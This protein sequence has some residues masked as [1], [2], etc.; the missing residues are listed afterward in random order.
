MTEPKWHREINTFLE[1]KP[2]IILD[3][4]VLDQFQF[5]GDSYH[6]VYLPNY[7]YQLLKEKGYKTVVLYDEAN[8]FHP[9]PGKED[10]MSRFLELC[11]DYPGVHV[12]NN[13][14]PCPFIGQV[15][16][17]PVTTTRASLDDSN[18]ASIGQIIEYVLGQSDMSVAVIMDM[19]SRYIVS[20]DRM[21]LTDV[22]AYTEIL[23]AIRSAEEADTG[24]NLSKNALIL[25]T[26][27]VNDLPTWFYLSNPDV[28]IISIPTPDN[29]LRM[30]FV[31]GKQFQQF[32]Q[33]EIYSS[34]ILFYDEH[35]ELLLK[36]RK[37]FVGVTE[38]FTYTD[39]LGIRTICYR[40][41][42]HISQLSNV[43]DFYR[44]GIKENKWESV[45]EKTIDALKNDLFSNILGQDFALK[46]VLD[47]V[48]RSVIS[49]NGNVASN[50]PKGILFFAGPT[51]TGKTETAKA[52]ARDIFGDE[53]C[54]LRFDMAEY[55]QSHSDQKLLGAPPGYVGYEAGGQL[56]NAVRNNPFS[57]ILFDEIE[58]A[59]PSILDKFLQI[60][61][62]GR[63]TDGQGNTVYF[64][65][66]IIVFTSNEGIIGEVAEIDEFGEKHIT[67]KQLIEASES[68]PEIHT[69]VV[70]GIRNYFKFELG[71][72]ELLNRIG[73][74]NIIVF[75]FISPQVAKDILKLQV[76]KI[77]SE[78][79]AGYGITIDVTNIMEILIRRCCSNEV[80]EY[81][82]RGIRNTVESC[83]Y[84]PLT[85]FVYDHR[86]EL[87]AG[88]CILV[89]DLK[90]DETP[91]EIVAEVAL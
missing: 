45:D 61:D 4:N 3:G 10:E 64:S 30:N 40:G 31:S 35:P 67:K 13:S 73:E 87:P 47:V 81:G 91:V 56:T 1:I 6:N 71:R 12:R 86:R 46:K 68:Y 78:F 51:G 66:S 32:F 82:G 42:Y 60:L 63:L 59:H 90:L 19:A 49:A 55:K 88:S 22:H 38:G 20:P 43:V 29:E 44:F 23:R 70:S 25:I 69:K 77:L 26:N 28:K 76:D 54:L 62:D 37:R 50:R 80:L 17:V 57:I 7:V 72:P 58:K 65:E 41:K 53:S 85:R 5:P 21:E 8:G 79:Q 24:D 33:P 27:K 74:D 52:L 34:D 11:K 14:I 48:K 15:D 84:T 2:C 89:S 75:N 16:F 39:L 36:L 18:N 83:L 9:L